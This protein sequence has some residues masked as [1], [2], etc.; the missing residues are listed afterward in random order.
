M[1]L[2]PS[3]FAVCVTY[4]E[5]GWKSEISIEIERSGSIEEERKITDNYFGKSVLEE[6]DIFRKDGEANAK[7][8]GRLSKNHYANWVN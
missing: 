5:T 4:R 1:I 7:Q 8:V 3:T 6:C 2:I